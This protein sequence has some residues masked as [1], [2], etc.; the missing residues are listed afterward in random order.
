MVVSS[1]SFHCVTH[2][3]G[4][5]CH[6]RLLSLCDSL[7]CNH[8]PSAT[9]ALSLTGCFHCATHWNI[10]EQ[11]LKQD[12]NLRSN[13]IA[14]HTGAEEPLVDS[15][16]RALAAHGHPDELDVGSLKPNKTMKAFTT[17]ESIGGF[18][19]RYVTPQMSFSFAPK[20]PTQIQGC[21][22]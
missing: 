22:C 9:F 18:K 13:D 10:F 15:I 5:T 16:L 7:A 6:R 17:P 14:S 1:L 8:M 12:N 19:F 21:L 2:W 20:V 11:L 3:A 4:I